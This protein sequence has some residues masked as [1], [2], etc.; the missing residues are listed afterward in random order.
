MR[1][2]V[3]AAAAVLLASCESVNIGETPQHALSVFCGLHSSAI[4]QLLLSEQAMAAGK[5]LCSIVGAG[6]GTPG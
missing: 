2:T 4:A 3:L 5:L 1:K 6:L